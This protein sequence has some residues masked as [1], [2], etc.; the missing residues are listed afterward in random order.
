M[1]RIW[2]VAA[3]DFVATVSA[4]GF[5]IG[6]L[7]G[8][9]MILL[10]VTLMPRIVNSPSPQVRGEVAVID[11]TGSVLP[12]LR[13]ALAPDSIAERRARNAR[14]LPPGAP[15]APG[16]AP[17]PMLGV[18]E[19]P[20][21]AEAQQEKSWLIGQAAEAGHHLALIVIPQDA[22]T[23]SPGKAEYGTYELYVAKGVNEAT[24]GVIH[25]A[26]REALVASRLK[27]QGIDREDIEA[28]MRVQRPEA[29]VVAVQ[30]EQA[31][32]RVLRRLLPFICGVLLFI[33]VITGGTALMTS[34]IEE[35]SSRVIEVLL[36]AVSPL[37]LMCGKLLAQ[38]GVS[39]LM[40]SVYVGLGLFS[41]F[42]F[43]VEGV[44]EPMLVVYL[45]LF[46][47]VAYLTYGA[48]MLT[49]GAAVSQQSDAQSMLT[50]V[51]LLLVLPY[52]LAGFI[53]QAPNSAL[54]VTLSFVPPLNTFVMLA[55]LASD[56]PPP[57]W[58][59][60]LTILLGLAFAALVLWFA[61]KVFRI[62][63]LIHGKPP[64]YATLIR[65]ARMA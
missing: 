12:E 18:M 4:K 35:K 5:L 2:M 54:S 56:A 46:F 26:L 53:G 58:Q 14:M 33:A 34:T 47:L 28:T 9:A 49:I 13:V 52:M 59:V 63:L 8:P 24:E 19:R 65:W 64:S 23:R 29:I 62:A 57:A 16:G 6:L 15:G 61:A 38:L 22:R 25:D 44:L 55:R 3:R 30:G 1:S 31:A 48:L 11:R 50:P 36:A 17:V 32:N 51:M 43:T 45:G 40:L 27:A 39:L 41:L 21:S 7:L 42:Q 37:E 60:A 10:L 20:A